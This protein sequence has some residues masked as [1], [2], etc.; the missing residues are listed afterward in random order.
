MRVT[1]GTVPGLA[2]ILV[3]YRPE[4]VRYVAIKQA[5]ARSAGFYSMLSHFPET[6]AEGEILVRFQY[7]Y[8]GIVL[9]H[10][11]LHLFNEMKSSFLNL[12]V[13]IISHATASACHR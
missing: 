7:Y 2:T 13:L 3:G 8:Q 5:V 9:C 10:L 6:V 12:G 4:S 1:S 11:P